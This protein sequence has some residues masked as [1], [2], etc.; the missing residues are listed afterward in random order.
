M[1]QNL[2]ADSFLDRMSAYPVS[3]EVAQNESDEIYQSLYSASSVEVQRLLPTVLHY[4]R[5]GNEVKVRLYAVLFLTAIAMRPDGAALLSSKSEEIA[6]L[7]VDSDLGVQRGALAVMDYLIGK[8]GTDNQPYLS[9]LQT[10]IQNTQTPQDA[11]E[12]MAETL[13]TFGRKDPG[14]LKSV[15]TFMRREDLTRSTQIDLV[16]HLGL[17]PGLPTG[18]TQALVKE[19]DNPDPW[20]RAA[21]VAAFA[22]SKTEFYTTE[23]HI[24]A[25]DRVATMASDPHENPQVR[26]LAKEA[27]EGKTQL[28]P[29]IDLLLEDRKDH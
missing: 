8:A 19:L 5:I 9:A 12:Q 14:V 18:V 23:F 22:D 10:A 11:G 2:S 4:T 6:S 13:L 17:V 28:N 7:I 3:D 16:S 20:V 15:L 27:I 26:E 29:N 24:L 25:K 21:A 1:A